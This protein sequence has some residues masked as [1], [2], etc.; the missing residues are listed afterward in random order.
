MSSEHPFSSRFAWPAPAKINRFLHVTGR[1]SDGYHTLQTLFQFID[2]QDDLRFSARGDSEFVLH[3][4]PAALATEDNLIL[5]AARLM[6]R[7]SGAPLGADIYLTKRI[8][9]GGGLGG[10]SSNA[11]TTL[12]A[13]NR[14]WNLGFPIDELAD[15]GATLGAD[16]PVFVR[17]TAAWGEGIGE[18]LSPVT[19]AESWLVLAM[20]AV[21]VP[22]AAVFADP[23]LPRRHPSVTWD[24][25]EAG[26]CGNDCE[27]VVCARYPEV[28]RA[29]DTLRAFG[30]AR[31]SG[32]GA[33]VFLSCVTEADA[34]RI[35]AALPDGLQRI[36]TRGLNHSPLAAILHGL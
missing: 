30:Q 9:V 28:A 33:C 15:L 26:R 12:V 11:A 17:G 24:D 29:L 36:I 8:P 20:P 34:H 21:T 3:D 16:V 14:L 22:T 10:G 13:L 5:R 27:E 18:R 31:L 4:A 23:A 1:R 25:Y 19:L 32:T 35:D 7:V 2:L 6:Q